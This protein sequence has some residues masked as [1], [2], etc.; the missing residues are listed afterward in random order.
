MGLLIPISC[1]E[2]GFDLMADERL[3]DMEVI[4]PL[5]KK[6]IVTMSGQSLTG[7]FL[8]MT[9]ESL[10]ALRRVLVGRLNLN[11]WREVLLL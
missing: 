5:E 8:L 7:V 4:F 2:D 10:S 11:A 1:A 9:P 3:A 6:P